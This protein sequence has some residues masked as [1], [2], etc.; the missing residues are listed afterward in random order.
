MSQIIGGLILYDGGCPGGGPQGAVWLD[1]FEITNVDGTPPATPPGNFCEAGGSSP[2]G[3]TCPP[4]CVR[5]A[6]AR[7]V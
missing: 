4:G 6:P 3:S 5:A 2:L 7:P 1:D